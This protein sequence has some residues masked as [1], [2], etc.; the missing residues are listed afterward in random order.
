MIFICI[1]LFFTGFAGRHFE[2]GAS[3]GLHGRPTCLGEDAGEDE[4]CWSKV[5]HRAKESGCL[6]QRRGSA[7]QSEQAQPVS[8]CFCFFFKKG[9]SRFLRGGR[10]LFQ[11][12]EM[13]LWNITADAGL[14]LKQLFIYFH[15]LG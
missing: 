10:F 8:I 3:D 4:S 9:L 2:G 5:F 11:F 7:D 13:F 1:F 15:Q 6:G 12:A 14:L